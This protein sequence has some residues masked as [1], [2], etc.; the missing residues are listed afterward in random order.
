MEDPNTKTELNIDNPDELNVPD[1]VKGVLKKV[2]LEIK[3]LD[4]P[5]VFFKLE[6]SNIVEIEDI[7]HVFIERYM[8]RRGCILL[9]LQKSI[10]GYRKL[11]YYTKTVH[12][13][14]QCFGT[15]PSIELIKKT[16][17]ELESDREKNVIIEAMK[18][19]LL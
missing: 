17:K 18:R 16:K 1:S 4:N 15:T 11:W 10:N 7:K 14:A 5:H 3:R 19:K 2:I 9:A 13:G 8:Y 6:E 12:H